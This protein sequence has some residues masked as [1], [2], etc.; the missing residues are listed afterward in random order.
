VNFND[1]PIRGTFI[2]TLPYN[3]SLLFVLYLNTITSALG[4][5][6][7]FRL[8]V[9]FVVRLFVL[10]NRVRFLFFFLRLFVR[11]SMLGFGILQGVQKHNSYF[12]SRPAVLGSFSETQIHGFAERP[13]D[14]I[15]GSRKV[16][17]QHRRVPPRHHLANLVHPVGFHFPA[18]CV[19]RQYVKEQIPEGVHVHHFV[20]KRSGTTGVPE[21]DFFGRPPPRLV[22]AAGKSTSTVGRGIVGEKF[23]DIEIVNFGNT[24]GKERH[25]AGIEV[26]VDHSGRGVGIVRTGLVNMG[27]AQGDT[28]AQAEFDRHG[29]GVVFAPDAPVK[30]F[31]I[32]HA[33]EGEIGVFVDGRLSA[34][35]VYVDDVIGMG[36]SFHSDGVAAVEFVVLGFEFPND[37]EGFQY[38][39]FGLEGCFVMV[40]VVFVGGGDSGGV[41]MARV[42]VLPG[43]PEPTFAELGQTALIRAE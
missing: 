30:V 27:N 23:S 4:F 3:N 41:V 15:F 24:T 11:Q 34:V 5:N 16:S 7:V 21:P 20:E 19:G 28:G 36:K 2:S 38:D 6:H 9:G 43:G 39:G 42:F 13:D 10:D 17:H 18:R 22:H 26:V 8:V 33:A 40:A 12:V 31:E 14:G 37:A 35:A 1:C 32:G 25:V 29:A